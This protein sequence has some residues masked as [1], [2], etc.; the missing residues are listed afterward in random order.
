MP[1]YENVLKFYDF[2]HFYQA[3]KHILLFHTWVRLSN[4]SD[5]NFVLP[6]RSSL[7]SVFIEKGF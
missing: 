3:F 1:E 7:L 6:D 2:I 5:I 4:N